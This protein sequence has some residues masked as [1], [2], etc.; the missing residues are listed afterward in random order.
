MDGPWTHDAQRERQTEKDTQRVVPSAGS[1]VTRQIH[2]DRK[3]AG[4]CRGRGRGWGGDCRG[5]GLLGGDENVLK[6]DRGGSYTAR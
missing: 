5:W 6:L 2:R 3:R 1:M 4:G